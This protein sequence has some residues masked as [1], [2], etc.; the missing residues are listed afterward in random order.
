MPADDAR[1][2]VIFG[3]AW[4][5]LDGKNKLKMGGVLST[6]EAISCSP[7]AWPGNFGT[8]DAARNLA[9]GLQAPS[10][11]MRKGQDRLAEHRRTS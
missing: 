6:A 8:G 9:A 10:S 5:S 2:V 3:S 1:A 7:T 4:A 11:R